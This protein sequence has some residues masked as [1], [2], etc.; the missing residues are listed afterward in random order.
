MGEMCKL[1]DEWDGVC[2]E[3]S[4]ETWY[5]KEIVALVSKRGIKLMRCGRVMEE[6]EVEG[7]EGGAEGEEDEEE[8]RVWDFMKSLTRV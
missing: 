1:A 8:K 6:Y 5:K 4:K 2:G 7:E 3:E